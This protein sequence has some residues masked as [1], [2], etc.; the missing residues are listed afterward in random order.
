MTSDRRPRQH[1]CSVTEPTAVADSHRFLGLRLN[2]DRTLDIDVTMVLIGDVDVMSRP[3]VVTD[4]DGQV[5]DDST[6]TANEASI[7]DANHRIRHTFLTRNHAS[8]K[9]NVRADHR[10]TADLDVGLVEDRC[11]WKADDTSLAEF[12][13]S[14]S[15]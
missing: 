13:K 10:V 3:H 14:P 12:G 9:G 11:V 5:T 4:V 1:D 7:T 6:T 8:R 2:R 15:P